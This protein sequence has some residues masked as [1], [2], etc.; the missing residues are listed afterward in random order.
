MDCADAL[1]YYEAI[2]VLEAQDA[3]VTMNISD[4]P[5]MKKDDRSKFYRE[6]RKR[7]Y[8]QHLQKQMSFEDFAKKVGML[9]GR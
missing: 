1:D 4:Y 8:P 7:A 9:D 3:L 2:T 6:M 5:R